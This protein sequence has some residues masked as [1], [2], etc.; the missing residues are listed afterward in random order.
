MA[1]NQAPPLDGYDPLAADPTLARAIAREGGGWALDDIRRF[2]LRVTSP[3]VIGWGEQANL[4]PPRL[5][6]H[7]R[8]GD[9]LDHVEFHPAWHH[10]LELSIGEGLHSLPFEQPAGSGGRVVRDAK[11]SL[12]SQIEAGHGCPISMTTAVNYTLSGQ[13]D[14]WGWR[15]KILS[16]TYDRRPLAAGEKVGLL[17]GMGMTEKQG[18]SDVRANLTEARPVGD[19]HVITG[20]KWFLSAPMCDGFL[21]L[22]QTGAGLTC[23]LIPRLTPDGRTNGIRL[24]R[25]KDKLGNRSNASSEVELDE[26]WGVPIGEE[27]RG[28]ATIIEMV[29]GTRLDCVV[30]SVG[31]MRQAVTQA[32][33]HTTHRTAF[34]SLL[35]DKPLMQ[36]VLADLE[37][38]VEAATVLMMRLSGAFDRADLDPREAA[39]KRIATPLVKYWV[40]KRCSEVV[41]EA[42]ECVGGN[43]YVEESILPRLYRESPVNAIWEGSGNVVA[44]DLLRAMTKEPDTFAVFRQEALEAGD[45]RIQVALDSLDSMLATG[46]EQ[47]ARRIAQRMA[48]ILAGSMLSRHGDPEVTERFLDSRLNGA[49]EP[50]FG[51]LRPGGDLA[52]I[53]RRAVPV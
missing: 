2:G 8:F 21:M 5:L 50:L 30:G 6:T 22:A 29:N 19:G 40:T 1:V 35:I 42:L 49:G 48:V 28:V 34:G 20:H 53:A 13:G 47:G 15:S 45:R 3:E 18:G 25:L 32:A 27:G 39:F 16:R 26:A 52:A 36:N 7:D 41:R 51:G 38:E 9:R 31:L 12:M 24:L 33:W 11:F 46:A 4:N 44:L 14:P 17:L 37:I 10:L 43:G 23:F